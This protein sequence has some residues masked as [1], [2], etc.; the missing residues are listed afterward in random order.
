MDR[1]LGFN[2]FNNGLLTKQAQM[3]FDL[4]KFVYFL[5]LKQENQSMTIFLV[6]LKF[7]MCTFNM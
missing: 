7:L 4:F 3:K 6:R 2:C 5:Y 1:K